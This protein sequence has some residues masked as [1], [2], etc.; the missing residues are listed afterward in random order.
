[1]VCLQGA[2]LS[3][4][5]PVG[6]FHFLKGPLLRNSKSWSMKASLCSTQ[7]VKHCRAICGLDVGICR[8]DIFCNNPPPEEVI[9]CTVSVRQV[10]AGSG[11]T[12]TT[13]GAC[14][15]WCE[16]CWAALVSP[17]P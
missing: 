15:W 16:T 14:L 13:K 9:C 8:G 6:V 7:Q 3:V 2:V 12:Q 11:R 5:I 17:W 1:M 4:S 10:Q